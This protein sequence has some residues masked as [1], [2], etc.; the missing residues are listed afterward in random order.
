MTRLRNEFAAIMKLLVY[1]SRGGD[2]QLIVGEIFV[3][4]KPG[5]ISYYFKRAGNT[6]E[7]LTAVMGDIR[8]NPMSYLWRMFQLRR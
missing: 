6:L 7:E 1:G 3:A 2:L 5:V 4:Y 8:E